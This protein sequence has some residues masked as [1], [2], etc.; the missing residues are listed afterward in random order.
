[1]WPETGAGGREGAAGVAGGAG[2]GGA[3]THCGQK[4][5]REGGQCCYSAI[6]LL[7]LLVCYC[8]TLVMPLLLPDLLP[9]DVIHT[10]LIMRGHSPTEGPGAWTPEKHAGQVPD[11]SHH[12]SPLSM[13]PASLPWL[14]F[15]LFLL[16][17]WRRVTHN[18][19][20]MYYYSRGI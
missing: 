7:L 11:R 12:T 20:F 9:V 6:A 18:L 4:Q 19:L 17:A 2:V 16:C 10:L 15:F 5:L 3:G 8:A 13:P 14:Y 1:M